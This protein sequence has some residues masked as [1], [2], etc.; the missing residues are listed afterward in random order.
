MDSVKN[1]F[2]YVKRI[3]KSIE[4]TSR[5]LQDKSMDDLIDDGFL[6]DAIENRFTKIAEDAS[7]LSAEFKN[8]LSIIPWNGI[9]SIRN[10]VC[11]DY[12]VVDFAILYKTIKINFPFF[13][14]V[15]IDS[16]GATIMD[17]CPEPFKLI[18]DRSKRVE[19]RINDERR[20]SLSIGDLIILKNT[21][22]KEEVIVEIED[23]K[24]FKTFNELYSSFEKSDLGYKKNEIASPDDMLNYYTEEQIKKYGVLAITI[25]LF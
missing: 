6:C 13:R 5:Y 25:R 19:M 7:N 16:V 8:K 22:T 9:S 18:A 12:D 15:L 2:Y 3:L 4:V 11:H 24:K 20:Q 14:K 23:I 21:D 1:D 17:V 10:R